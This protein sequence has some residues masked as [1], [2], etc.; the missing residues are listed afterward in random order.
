MSDLYSVDLGVVL[1]APA[2]AT[3]HVATKQE[4]VDTPTGRR[5][6]GEPERDEHGRPLHI[7]DVLVPLGRDGQSV[8]LGVKLPGFE[9]P[10]VDPLALVTF[11]GMRAYIKPPKNG[12]GVEVALSAATMHVQ[13]AAKPTSRRSG[14]GETAG[15]EGAA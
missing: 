6:S 4:W 8:V 9:V 12:R 14:G 11:E 1:D 10:T 7:V 15:S 3:G 2:I 13:G 5:L